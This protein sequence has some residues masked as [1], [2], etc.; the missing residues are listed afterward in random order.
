MARRSRSIE[1]RLRGLSVWE[2]ED[3]AAAVV[4]QRRN[5]SGNGLANPLL[6]GAITRSYERCTVLC[7][8]SPMHLMILSQRVI[9]SEVFLDDS[10]KPSQLVVTLTCKRADSSIVGSK[11]V[12][13]ELNERACVV[14]AFSPRG[15]GAF[16]TTVRQDIPNRPIYIEPAAYS[17]SSSTSDLFAIRL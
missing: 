11:L 3:E 17:S 12:W 10:L 8:K 9:A 14:D 7:R 15:E 4:A 5:G 13:E 1:R 6:R 16:L 2:E